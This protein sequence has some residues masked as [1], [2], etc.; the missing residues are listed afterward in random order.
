M[1]R[2]FVSTVYALTTKETL[3]LNEGADESSCHYASQIVGVHK[4][5]LPPLKTNSSGNY[6][7]RIMFFIP[8]NMYLKDIHKGAEI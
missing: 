4:S 2:Q 3:Q 5:S 7:I 1:W 8:F 6:I